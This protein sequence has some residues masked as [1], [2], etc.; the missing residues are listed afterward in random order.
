MILTEAFLIAAD[1][2]AEGMD[3]ARQNNYIGKDYD[4][5]MR[6]LLSLDNRDF[7]GWMLDQKRTEN[8]VRHNGS[9]ITMVNFQVFDPLTGQHTEY[10]DEDS[11]R[12]AMIEIS[13]KILDKYKITLVRSIVN[14]NGDTAWTSAQLTNPLTVCID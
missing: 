8:Y 3:I 7:A 9:I 6:D 13:K 1:A 4:W 10:P 2:C 11:A 5:V 12:L 14:E